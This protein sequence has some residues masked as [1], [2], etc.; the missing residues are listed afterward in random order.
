M[1]VPRYVIRVIPAGEPVH[2]LPTVFATK[3]EALKT[4]PLAAPMLYPGDAYHRKRNGDAVVIHRDGTYVAT[5][6]VEPWEAWQGAD[7]DA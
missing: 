6:G 1:S 5:I 3:R 2:D 4:L 7:P